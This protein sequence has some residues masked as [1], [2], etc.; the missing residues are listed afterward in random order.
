MVGKKGMGIM[1][2]E[3]TGCLGGIWLVGRVRLQTWGVWLSRGWTRSSGRTK[4][5]PASL[6][7]KKC[8]PA[9]QRA[10][11]LPLTKLCQS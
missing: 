5:R 7:Q 4:R 11:V 6:G 2:K 8:N 10:A 3:C 9:A 1:A